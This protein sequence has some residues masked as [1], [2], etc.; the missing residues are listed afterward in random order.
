MIYN[1]TKC[2]D[3]LFTGYGSAADIDVTESGT[4]KAVAYNAQEQVVDEDEISTVGE[5]VTVKLT[6]V[7]GPDGL[8]ADGSDIAY[9]D[10]A[11]V[12]KDGNTCPL[13]YNKLNMSLAG[14]GVLLGGYNSGV[15]NKITTNNKDFCYAECGTNRIFVRSTREAGDITLS[16][17]LDGQ[18][19]VSATITSEALE[20]DGG[21]KSGYTQLDIMNG[22]TTLIENRT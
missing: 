8:I 20:L 17:S 7:T 6:P 13:A 22:S 9:F 19:P 14:K 1:E 12:D 10:V 11:V 21:L 16:V 2:F 5:A 15:G 3:N 4:V 18:S